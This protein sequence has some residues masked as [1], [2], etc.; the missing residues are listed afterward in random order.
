V[1]KCASNFTP[2]QVVNYF[3][4]VSKAKRS[5]AKQ[6]KA[7]QSKALLHKSHNCP[8]YITLPLTKDLTSLNVV[9][10]VTPFCP[11]LVLF[12]TDQAI[13]PYKACVDSEIWYKRESTNRSSPTILNVTFVIM[14][15]VTKTKILNGVH[16]TSKEGFCYH[17]SQMYY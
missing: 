13:R 11:R 3:P 12:L 5:K 9:L 10:K 4:Y 7:K 15:S 6:S 16:E 1:T 2:L 17:L 8:Q 14:W